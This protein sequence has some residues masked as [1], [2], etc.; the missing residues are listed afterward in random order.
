MFSKLRTLI[1]STA[2]LTIGV[3]ASLRIYYA[4]VPRSM[5]NPLPYLLASRYGG[6]IES[7]NGTNYDVFFNDAGAAHSGN[8][9]T[10]IIDNDSVFGKRV[11]I[12]GYLEPKYAFAE[13]EIL[14]FWDDDLPIIQFASGR[15]GK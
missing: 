5:G 2:F 1:L 4:F 15:Y 7:P 9:W 8:H 14:V 12:E 3:C 6:V 13:N 10:W 11:V